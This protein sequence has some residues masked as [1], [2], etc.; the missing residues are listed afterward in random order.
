MN[1]RR[2]LVTALALVLVAIAVAPAHGAGFAPFEEARIILDAEA[3]GR[4]EVMIGAETEEVG[5]ARVV[6]VAPDGRR[7][8]GLRSN[9]SEGLGS[10]ELSFESVETDM[11]T[12][13]A[14]YPAGTYRLFGVGVDGTLFSGEADLS[15]D[16]PDPAQVVSP[17]VGEEISLGDPLVVAWEAVADAAAYVAQVVNLETGVGFAVEVSPDILTVTVPGEVVGLGVHLVGVSVV[18]ESGN[19]IEVESLFRVVE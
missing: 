7:V 10:P 3:D 1:Y 11:G 17:G 5:L 9:D 4:I 16:L 19:K 6:A 12:L 18:A 8:A 14:A 2:F 13:M 15:Y